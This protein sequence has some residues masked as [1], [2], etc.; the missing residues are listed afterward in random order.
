LKALFAAVR[1]PS[2]KLFWRDCKAFAETSLDAETYCER[3]AVERAAMD[4]TASSTER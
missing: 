1:L 3:L 2:D 4:M